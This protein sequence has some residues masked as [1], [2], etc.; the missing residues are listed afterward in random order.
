MLKSEAINQAY[1]EIRISGLTA[2]Q[3]PEETV[4]ALRELD[5]MMAQW[6][7]VGRDVNYNF[8]PPTTGQELVQSDPSETFGVFSWAINGVIT[9][10]ATRLVT[11][12]GKETP[13]ALAGKNRGNMNLIKQQTVK[14]DPQQYPRRMPIGSGNRFHAGG[15]GYLARYYYP[16]Y[17]GRGQ[18]TDII[19]TQNLDLTCDFSNDLAEGD[20]IESYTIAADERGGVSLVS[21]SIDGNVVSYRVLAEKDR[22][23]KVEI[24]GTTANGL[25]L[26]KAYCFKTTGNSCVVTNG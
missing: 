20:T 2:T 8:P 25:V 3:V 10:L 14:L 18:R 23:G 11:Y 4:L 17:T 19:V 6:A 15:E 7:A 5:Q 21:D 16:V 9:S 13:A 1:A 24:V 26:P 12:F 22:D